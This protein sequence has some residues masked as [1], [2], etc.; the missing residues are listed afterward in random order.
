MAGMAYNLKK[1][2]QIWNKNAIEGLLEGLL[3]DGYMLDCSYLL[4]LEG[5]RREIEFHPTRLLK[6]RVA[7]AQPRNAWPGGDNYILQGRNFLT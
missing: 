2:D 7:V 1:I 5:G 4:R 3:S 6:I